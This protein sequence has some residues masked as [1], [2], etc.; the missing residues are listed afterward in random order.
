MEIVKN[1]LHCLKK[2]KKFHITPEEY[3]AKK[4][5]KNFCSKIDTLNK[6]KYLPKHHYI[7]D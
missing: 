5:I 2:Y 6:T 3:K 1:S 7:V 4:V